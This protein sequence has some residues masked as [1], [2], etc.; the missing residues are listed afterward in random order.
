MKISIEGVS[1]SGKTTILR[2]LEKMGYNCYMEGEHYKLKDGT[3]N[4]LSDSDPRKNTGNFLSDSDPR[5]NNSNFLSGISNDTDSV[6]SNEPVTFSQNTQKSGT[7]FKLIESSPYVLKRLWAHMYHFPVHN[8]NWD[9]NSKEE[10]SLLSADWTPDY[11][12]FLDCQADIC[13]KR[14]QNVS[15]FPRNLSALQI[16]DLYLQLEWILHPVNCDIPIYR[17]NAS[18]SILHTLHSVL[19]VLDTILKRSQED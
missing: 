3:G 12:I 16:A 19:S 9:K 18:G 13:L 1:G 2:I 5:K 8:K 14:L 4:F 15:E 10:E 11:I 6:I 7:S 17:I